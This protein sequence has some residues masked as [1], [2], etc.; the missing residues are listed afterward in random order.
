M[1]VVFMECYLKR[2]LLALADNYLCSYV[3]IYCENFFIEKRQT[4][5]KKAVVVEH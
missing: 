1:N 5:Q 2:Q 3:L 4:R